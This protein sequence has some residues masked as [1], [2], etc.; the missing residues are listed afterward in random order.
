MDP[1]PPIRKRS[2]DLHLSVTGLEPRP[3]ELPPWER[4]LIERSLVEALD[5]GA[6]KGAGDA[7]E[8]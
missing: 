1:T 8:R 5:R 3:V 2:R 7:H 6:V 4:R